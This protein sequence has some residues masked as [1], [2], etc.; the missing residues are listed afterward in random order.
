VP[1]TERAAPRRLAQDLLGHLGQVVSALASL[2]RVGLAGRLGGGGLVEEDV[3]VSV[4]LN[5]LLALAGRL[6]ARARLR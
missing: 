4:D 3:E 1:V 5:P 2:G 6:A